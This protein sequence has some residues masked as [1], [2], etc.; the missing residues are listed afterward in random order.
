M[1][2]DRGPDWRAF[3]V[4]K[5]MAI[6]GSLAVGF[7]V[8]AI[9]PSIFWAIVGMDNRW[10]ALAGLGIGTAAGILGTINAYHWI[11]SRKEEK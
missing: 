11:D 6:G 5:G 9:V 10:E 3:L 2:K 4:T 1:P 8:W 7:L